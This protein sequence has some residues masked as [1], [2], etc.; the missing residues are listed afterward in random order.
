VNDLHGQH[1]LAPG[2]GRQR[3]VAPRRLPSHTVSDILIPLSGALDLAEGRAPGHARRVAFIATS[4]AEELLLEPQLRLAACYAALAHD[5]GVVAAGAGLA[6]YT[7]GDERLIFASH[8]LLTP[9]EMAIGLSEPPE[10]I[11]DRITDHVV[12][13]ARAA[14]ALDLPPEAI[15][16]VS[17]HHEHWDGSGYPHGLR[18]DAI[19]IVGRIVALADQ[20]EA[21]INQTEAL[22]A[23]RNIA[24]WLARLAGNEADPAVAEACRR[25]TS[26]DGFWLT[27][28]SGSLED[29]LARI[30]ARLHEDKGVRVLT[31]GES[32]AELVDSRL[33]F[34]AGISGKVARLVEKL[35]RAIDLPT[36]RL[37]RLRIAALLHDIGELAVPERILAKPGILTV[38]ELEV[39]RMHPLYSR[40][41]VGGISGLDDV[42]DWV[43]HHHEWF[44][45]KGYPDNR[46]GSEIPLEAR[47]LA[48][49]DAYV[50]LTSDRPYRP[51][52]ESADA[53]RRLLSG[54]GT[55]WDPRLVDVFVERVVG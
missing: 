35:G 21:M 42:A 48:I 54:A 36:W 13:G 55:Q 49:A 44:D 1:A 32:F 20:I 45:G 22:L 53:E 43:A 39:L 18:G 33:S 11:A 2:R 41:I 7:R 52:A 27:L 5:V 38:E 19:S 24:L 46:A 16:G 23:R 6:A 29:D 47:M 31:L 12:H 34:K 51:R 4:I 17:A 9:D 8:P 40:D 37:R 50:A 14:K 3:A 25:L 30:C 28:F 10:L 26:G 15:R